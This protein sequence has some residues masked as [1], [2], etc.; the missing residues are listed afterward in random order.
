GRIE[1][2]GRMDFETAGGPDAEYR[3]VLLARHAFRTCVTARRGERPA[4]AALQLLVND[5]APHHYTGSACRVLTYPHD[6]LELRAPAAGG[7]LLAYRE[8]T[9]R[10][11][12]AFPP[13]LVLGSTLWECR[14]GT[15]EQSQAEREHMAVLP[16]VAEAIGLR[17][18]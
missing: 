9:L 15:Q 11:G 1:S 7:A 2:W 18:P 8:S 17:S 14:P 13:V 3:R 12:Y 4:H 5:A 10:P 16:F 6:A